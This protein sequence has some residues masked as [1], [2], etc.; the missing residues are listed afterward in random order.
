MPVRIYDISKKLGLE[1]KEVLAKAKELGITAAK[2]PSSSLDKITAQYLE[3]KLSGGKPV[4]VAAPPPVEP[5]IK[6]VTA[7]PPA[8]EPP[9]VASEPAAEATAAEAPVE[10]PATNGEPVVARAEPPAPVASPTPAAPPPPPAPTGP[11]VG[12]KIG[13]INLPKPP[14]R[15]GDKVGSV[16]LPPGR[17]GT[18]PLEVALI[19]AAAMAVRSSSSNAAVSPPAPVAS[20]VPRA[21]V[22]ASKRR[23]SRQNPP[24]P[25]LPSRRPARSFRSSRRLLSVN[26]RNNS[27]A[28][29]SRSSLI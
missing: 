4:A 3:E 12:D 10:A 9:P 28:S 21:A 18:P 16:K 11:Q 20:N 22:Q 25:N 6:L 2:V 13:F 14:A 5:Q 27:N 24:N 1:N 19:F 15:A 26:S 7:P 29:R 17:P 8:P 23:S